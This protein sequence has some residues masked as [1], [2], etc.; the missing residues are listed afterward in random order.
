MS[1]GPDSL[2]LLLLAR[3]ACPGRIEAATVD[4]GLRPESAS[5]AAQVAALC[6]RLGVP[7]ETLKVDVEK[8]NLQQAARRARYAAL[9]DWAR[10]HRCD[11]VLTAHHADD[12]AETLVMRLNRGSG[13]KGLAGVRARGIN[14][15]G[16][17][18]VLRP[19]IGWRKAELVAICAH[20][21]V[22]P[23]FDPSNLDVRFERA[24][25][26]RA[27]ADADWLDPLAIARS[28][29]FLAEADAALAHYAEREWE[30]RVSLEGQALR[31]APGEGSPREVVMRVLA[32][33]IGQLGGE[34]RR[35]QVADLLDALGRGEGGNL[36]GVWARPEPD[37]WVLEPEPSRR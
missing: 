11:A 34:P 33:A 36:A 10:A 28:A 17:G 8:G 31:Y 1:G 9:D 12:Q 24:R 22:E 27:L 16:A 20:C 30:T 2:A 14:P 25:I 26:R 23:V 4:H 37:G 6:R 21:G 7:H 3:E 5:E 29:Q 19:L 35:S 13:L 15:Q 32:R 18:V